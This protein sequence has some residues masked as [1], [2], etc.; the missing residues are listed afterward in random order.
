MENLD[1]QL[2][3]DHK[4]KFS[5]KTTKDQVDSV[6]KEVKEVLVQ[7][8]L[9]VKI[10]QLPGTKFSVSMA[11]QLPNETFVTEKKGKKIIPLLKKVKKTL[12]RRLRSSTQKRRHCRRRLRRKLTLV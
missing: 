4:D 6:V 9:Q 8:E 1:Y 5:K 10:E 3:L 12:L 2:I 7:G 11:A